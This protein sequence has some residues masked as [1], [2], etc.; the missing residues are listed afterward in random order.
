MLNGE[1]LGYGTGWKMTGGSAMAALRDDCD[2]FKSAE[3]VEP[4]DAR[5]DPL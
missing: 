5:S 1:T 4:A 3:G 2:T